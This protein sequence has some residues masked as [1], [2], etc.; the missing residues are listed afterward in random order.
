M[1]SSKQNT[2]ETVF[3]ETIGS[4]RIYY[5]QLQSLCSTGIVE[6]CGIRSLCWKILLNYLPNNRSSWIRVLEKQR[7][8][9]NNFLEEVIVQPGLNRTNGPIANAEDHPLNTNPSS[10]WNTYFKENSILLQIDKDVRRL[11][12]DISFFQNATA[13]P[14]KMLHLESSK[15][16]SLRKR[17]ERTGLN[18]QSLTRKKMGISNLINTRKQAIEEYETLM[19]QGQEAHWEVVERMLF[20]Y[21]K[22]N[23]GTGYVQGMNEIIGPLY[24]TFASDPN[25]KWREYAEAD[26][27][28]CFTLLM[29]DIRDN[30]I[31][32]LDRSTTGIDASMRRT[33]NLLQRS[34]PEVRSKLDKIKI[35]PE[36]F[37]FRWI[38]LLLSQEFPLPDV[39]HIWDVLFAD[40]NRFDLLIAVCVGMIMLIRKELLEKDFSGCVKLLQNYPEHIEIIRVIQEAKNVYKTI[41]PGS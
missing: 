22:L 14:C 1:T 40:E 25:P 26:T 30:F 41:H 15:V 2:R 37:L 7:Q 35:K 18:S 33:M 31:T 21:A 20:V 16:E 27:F 39:I 34:D 8:E 32:S 19:T 29:G 5:K 4:E 38:T 13:Y 23:P 17:I 36:Y 3:L 11:C 12:P 24:Y 6:T 28:F 9:Y 10:E